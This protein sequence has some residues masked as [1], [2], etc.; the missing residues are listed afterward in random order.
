MDSNE[1]MMQI[2]IDHRYVTLS[3]TNATVEGKEDRSIAY[4]KLRN[5][6]DDNK[7]HT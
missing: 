6:A 1:F 4:V 3:P 2:E 7:T 5:A